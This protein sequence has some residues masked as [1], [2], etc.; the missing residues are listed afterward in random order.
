MSP[1]SD[2]VAFFR[3]KRPWSRQ[4]DRVLEVYVPAYLQKV[5]RKPGHPILIVDGFAGPGRFQC[6]APGSPVILAQAIDAAGARFQP[7][8]PTPELLAV[9]P[10]PA[11]HARLAA[12]LA[13]YA[14]AEAASSEFAAAVPSIRERAQGKTAFLYLDPF[15]IAGLD[16]NGLVSI[17]ELVNEG[18]SV[19]LLLNFNAVAFVRV[20]RA[21]L[22]LPSPPTEDAEDED[23]GAWRGQAASADRLDAAVGGSWWKEIVARGGETINQAAAIVLALNEKLR[24]IC[25]E[26]C[27]YEVYDRLQH[28]ALKYALV[29]A[30]R[31]PVALVLMNDAMCK[32]HHEFLESA[33]SRDMPLFAPAASTA[34]R[35]DPENLEAMIL[36]EARCRVPREKLIEK[37]I[38]RL[39]RE[40]GLGMI[41]SGQINKKLTE[42]RRRTLI[43]TDPEGGAMNDDTIVWARQR[44]A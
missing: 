24:G 21:A 10:H 8:T 5:S 40:Q 28:N 11:L 2:P 39:S 44:S 4:K 27:F 12:E 15:A 20:A 13:P 26:V 23:F 43:C 6:G 29:F 25:K 16:W 19:E 41:S 37:T 35:R 33:A 14:F 36:G 18:L 9:E 22:A 38:E 32:A 1:S 17:M 34:F 30:T 7:N 3:E 31:S 42:M